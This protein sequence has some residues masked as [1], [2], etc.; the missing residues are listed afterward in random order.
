M[1]QCA[2]QALLDESLPRLCVA[3]AVQPE[4]D[5]EQDRGREQSGQAFRQLAR[6]AADVDQPRGNEPRHETQH[7]RADPPGMDPRQRFA[8]PGFDEKR[9]DG[10]HHE[11]RFQPFAH[12][13]KKCA[14]RGGGRRQRFAA[15]PLGA[16]AEQ[17]V[18]ASG[19]LRDLIAGAPRRMRS[20]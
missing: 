19:E 11:Q 4:A 13:N 1:L 7:E 17:S 2:F 9:D 18:D 16:G 5:V 8:P 20:R 12:E 10:R 15:E 3:L 14:H 6:G